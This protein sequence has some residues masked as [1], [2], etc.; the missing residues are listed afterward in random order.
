MARRRT[1]RVRVSDDEFVS[2][3]EQASKNNPPLNLSEWARVKMGLGHEEGMTAREFLSHE[4]RSV[5]KMLKKFFC[6][7]KSK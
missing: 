2:I 1:F 5:M 7:E 3:K 4:D 6:K